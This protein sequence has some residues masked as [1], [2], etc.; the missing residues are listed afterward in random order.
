MD[1]YATRLK[2]FMGQIVILRRGRGHLSTGP[3]AREIHG[4]FYVGEWPAAN[5]FRDHEITSVF[6]V[7][8][9]NTILIE[10]AD[11]KEQ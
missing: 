10:V 2:N 7:P 1:W 9:F 3:L 11:P 5:T 4:G 8:A 6:D